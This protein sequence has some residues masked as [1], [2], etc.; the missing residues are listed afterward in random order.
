[1]NSY[2]PVRRWSGFAGQIW[3]AVGFEVASCDVVRQGGCKEDEGA[4]VLLWQHSLRRRDLLNRRRAGCPCWRANSWR[5]SSD[6]R[7]AAPTRHSD[8]D[9]V[10][11]HLFGKTEA[12]RMRAALLAP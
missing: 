8:V 12:E 5:S 11:A 7:V 9:A 2:Q 1:V 3:Q 10:A 4:R 6:N